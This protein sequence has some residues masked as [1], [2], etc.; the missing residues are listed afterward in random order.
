M[1]NPRCLVLGHKW[2]KKRIEDS[3]YL[4]CVRCAKESQPG[5]FGGPLGAGF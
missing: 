4:L 2:R 5:N 1:T 3:V